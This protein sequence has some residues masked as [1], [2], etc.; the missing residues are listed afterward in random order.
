MAPLDLNRSCIVNCSATAGLHSCWL[1]LWS[2]LSIS[3]Q[4]RVIAHSAHFNV[5][6]CGQANSLS[7]PGEQHTMR[8]TRTI[9]TS[10]ELAI[11]SMLRI[12]CN[13]MYDTVNPFCPN[14]M[15]YVHC[16]FDLGLTLF[17][18]LVVSSYQNKCLLRGNTAPY[19]SW[20]YTSHQVQQ[21]CP[22]R[23]LNRYVCM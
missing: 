13:S 14:G 11:S 23:V 19:P 1:I 20:L 8:P 17:W 10:H 9:K 22:V 4:L 21:K 15:L 2:K 12:I 6:L 7:A 3:L 16:Q 5:T 18:L